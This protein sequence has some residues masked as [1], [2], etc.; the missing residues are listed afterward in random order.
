MSLE[1]GDTPVVLLARLQAKGKVDIPG[2]AQYVRHCLNSSQA[3]VL[4][5]TTLDCLPAALLADLLLQ[6]APL[7]EAASD[8]IIQ[9]LYQQHTIRSAILSYWSTWFK[10]ELFGVFCEFCH[11]KLLKK[12]PDCSFQPVCKYNFD[13]YKQN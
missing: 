11:S 13:L 8:R 1:A 10:S 5:P 7:R 12:T 2:L 9:R 4:P 6:C 3:P